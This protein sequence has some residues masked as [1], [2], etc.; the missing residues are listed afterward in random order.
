M[1]PWLL[2]QLTDALIGPVAPPDR[3][4]GAYPLLRPRPRLIPPIHGLFSALVPGFEMEAFGTIGSATVIGMGDFAFGVALE[5]DGDAPY[6]VRG[7]ARFGVKA[8]DVHLFLTLQPTRTR[9]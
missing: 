6:E 9:R 1:W 5:A 7:V 4:A 2:I 8:P 3:D